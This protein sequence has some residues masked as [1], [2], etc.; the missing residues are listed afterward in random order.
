MIN[1]MKGDCLDR[2]KEIP[3]GSV[4]LILTDPP[5]GTTACK[6][7]SVIPMDLMWEQLN[8]VIKPMGA[9]VIFASQPFTTTLIASNIKQFKYC[10]VWDKKQGGNPLNAKRQPLRVTEDVVVFNIKK[11]NPQMRTGR[12]RKKGGITKQPET[13]GKVDL[14]FSSYNDQYYPTNIL[15]EPNCSNKKSRVHP[16]QKPV[17]LMEYLV[18]TYTHENETVLDFTMGSGTTG[19]ACVNLGRKF[20]GIEMDDNYFEIASKRIHEAEK[21]PDVVELSTNNDW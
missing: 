21:T 19:V 17:K 20:I 7:D 9:I 4:D 11:Y 2:M 10:W 14:D 15:C 8:R 13:T 16:T 3:D 1:L 6:W 5:Y 18:K 12:L